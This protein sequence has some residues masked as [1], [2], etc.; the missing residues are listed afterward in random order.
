MVSVGLGF[1]LRVVILGFAI[2]FCVVAYV[3]FG[4]R[5]LFCLFVVFAA[6]FW[7]VN[8]VGIVASW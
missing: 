2:L 5:C 8:S 7:Y 3:G 1:C 4:S 6:M